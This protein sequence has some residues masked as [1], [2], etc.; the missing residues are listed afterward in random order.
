MYWYI[1]VPIVCYNI[2]LACLLF[3]LMSSSLFI[4]KVLESPRL[5]RTMLSLPCFPLCLFFRCYS[6][7]ICFSLTMYFVVIYRLVKTMISLLRLFLTPLWYEHSYFNISYVQ[8]F[9]V[10]YM[11]NCLCR[12]FWGIIGHVTCGVYFWSW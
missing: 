3:P 8:L 1:F 12:I 5:V 7:C 10:L 11:T 6:W 2:G 4:A 9:C